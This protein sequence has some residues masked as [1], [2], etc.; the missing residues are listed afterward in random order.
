MPAHEKINYVEYP[1]RDLS[2]TKKFFTQ[3]FGWKFEDYG[4]EYAAFS[5]EGLDGGFYKA[6]LAA[7]TANGSAL[8][9]FYSMALEDTLVK[10]AAAGG[11][12]TKPI[13]DFPGGRRFHFTEPS[14]NE[15]AVWGDPIK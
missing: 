13:F 9:V 14:G 12:I 5:G 10:V 2:A 1:S 11:S 3:A 7:S 4:P 8:V 6:D 15:F